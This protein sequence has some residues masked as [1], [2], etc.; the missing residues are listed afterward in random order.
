MQY[1]D[2]KMTESMLHTRMQYAYLQRC[3]ICSIAYGLD[4]PVMQQGRQVAYDR[5]EIHAHACISSID[6]A[7]LPRS[8]IDSILR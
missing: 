6:S 5:W 3:H 8:S 2:L 7:H 1:V 4:M